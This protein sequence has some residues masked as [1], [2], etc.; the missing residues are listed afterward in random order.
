M[1]LS[2][3]SRTI[4]SLVS[5]CTLLVS[6][7]V[8]AQT[9]DPDGLVA[10]YVREYQSQRAHSAAY[11]DLVQVL[12]HHSDYPVADL[13]KLLQGLE[14]VVVTGEPQRLRAE[15]AL[16][17]AIPGKRGS[18]R[19]IDT[20]PR[21]ERVYRRS[22][23]P[24]VRSVLVRA[25]GDLAETPQ[26]A[27]FLERIAKQETADFPEAQKRAL[28]SLLKMDD[29]GRTVLK[30]LHEANAVRDPTGKQMLADLAKQGY[31]LKY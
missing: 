25:M 28:V 2:S 6:G 5:L 26:A 11:R 31:R 30:R 4:T 13:E 23:D 22:T 19:P 14:Q 21:L 27:L 12:T 16:A 18:V 20:F 1:M 10:A 29:E 24:L 7:S 3:S 15:A 9:R 8:T 17:L